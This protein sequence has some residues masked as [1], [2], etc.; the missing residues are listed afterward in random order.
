MK[1]KSSSRAICVLSIHTMAF[2]V[3]LRSNISHSAKT[4]KIIYC[5]KVD[6][7]NDFKEFSLF[8]Q[9]IKHPF[10]WSSEQTERFF[11]KP[12]AER[13]EGS[14]STHSPKLIWPANMVIIRMMVK[15]ESSPAFWIRKKMA[16]E[17]VRFSTCAMASI[18]GNWGDKSRSVW[19][20]RAKHQQ[21]IRTGPVSAIRFHVGVSTW[22]K[23]KRCKRGT[24]HISQAD[25][26]EHPSCNGKD[27]VGR[28]AASQQDAEDQANVAG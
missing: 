20:S 23:F 26:E 14:C 8:I 28:K 4:E 11:H 5:L 21:Q 25:V 7:S 19:L 16:L 27:D 17:D 1:W 22:A 12:Q 2:E 10:H 9:S 24:Y 6:T 18:S 3:M 15:P 13:G